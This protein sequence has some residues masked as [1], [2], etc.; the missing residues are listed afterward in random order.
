[1]T[2]V[3]LKSGWVIKQNKSLGH[4]DSKIITCLASFPKWEQSC[5]TWASWLGLHSCRASS[6]CRC[7]ER[8]LVEW[9][10]GVPPEQSEQW[11]ENYVLFK[12]HVQCIAK[13]F[14]T[15]HKTFNILLHYV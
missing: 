15:C 13:I 4:I 12:C 5:Q 3:K 11:E 10:A 2:G 6:A 8:C 9:L 7:E 14:H 1:M